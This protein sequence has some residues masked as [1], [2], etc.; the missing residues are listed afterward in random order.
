[1]SAFLSRP[2]KALL[3]EKFY[4][5]ARQFMVERIPRFFD[6]IRGRDLWV[7]PDLRCSKAF[8][9]SRYNGKSVC[10]K[11]LS[12][13]S[14]VYSFGVGYDISFDLEL[15]ERTGC[16]VHAFD[17][18]PEVALWLSKQETPEQFRFHP[19]GLS[20]SDG[21]ATFSFVDREESADF[22]LVSETE[23][24]EENSFEAEVLTLETIMM[25][26]GHERLDLL[27]IDIE[28]AEYPVLKQ[29]LANEDP[30]FR[31]LLVEFHHRFTNIDKSETKT[32]LGLLRERGY[33]L[34][35]VDWAGLEYGFLKAA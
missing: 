25:R 35:S 32:A 11:D 22:T 2:I 24:Q 19:W 8:L 12:E 18:T 17:P 20:H 13:E 9:G 31:R 30:C 5:D 23:T 34:F 1:M 7:S 14:L 6:Q 33:G 28:G 21:K 10:L 29:I 3:P 27:K 4:L 15:I 16:Q 26:L